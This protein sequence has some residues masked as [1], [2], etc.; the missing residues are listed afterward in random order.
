MKIK[1]L[2]LGSAVLK[3]YTISTNNHSEEEKQ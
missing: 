1:N 2:L 3:K